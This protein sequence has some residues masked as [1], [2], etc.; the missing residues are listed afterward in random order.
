MPNRIVEPEASVEGFGIV[1]LEAGAC[2]LPVIAGNSGGAPDAV[3]HDVT[4]YLV[5]PADVDG[6]SSRIIALLSDESLR[7][8]MG[9][10]S[11]RRIIE[12]FCEDQIAERY[13]ESSV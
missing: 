5:N 4:G 6:I 10:A 9:R 3:E 1:F 11:R 8:T 7:R 13:L 2:E 12:N